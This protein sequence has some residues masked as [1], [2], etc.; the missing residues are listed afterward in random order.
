MPMPFW[1]LVLEALTA[2][3]TEA[4]S[5]FGIDDNFTVRLIS[6]SLMLALI[7]LAR[8]FFSAILIFVQINFYY[9]GILQSTQTRKI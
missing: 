7:K 2:A 8:S 3:F 9:Y 5:I 1:V 6:A 4:I